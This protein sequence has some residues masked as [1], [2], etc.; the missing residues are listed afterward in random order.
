MLEP[1]P[2]TLPEDPAA[3]ALR[4]RMIIGPEDGP[5]EESFDLTLCTPEWLAREV[6]GGFYDPRHHLVVDVEAFDVSALRT[7]L[8]KRVQSVQADT[9]GEMGE[10]LGRL[11]YWEFEDYRP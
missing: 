5:G 11:G 8:A 4:A 2:K 1:D 10:R 7:W 3:F 9:W 6:K